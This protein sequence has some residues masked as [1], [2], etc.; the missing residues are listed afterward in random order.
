MILPTVASSSD[1]A[2]V[3]ALRSVLELLE[4]TPFRVTNRVT[5]SPSRCMAEQPDPSCARPRD[6]GQVLRPGR[7]SPQGCAPC[8]PCTR[9]AST[10]PCAPRRPDD[11]GT[12]S[13][14][15]ATTEGGVL[16]DPMTWCF[17]PTDAARPGRPKASACQHTARGELNADE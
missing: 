4:P 13:G 1:F 9:D 10:W 6:E 7:G 8:A 12:T 2:E 11:V 14:R 3:E 17:A 5:P 15:Y 16:V